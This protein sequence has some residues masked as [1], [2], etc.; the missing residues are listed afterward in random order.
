VDEL[1]TLYEKGY[2]E[3]LAPHGNVVGAVREI[4]RSCPDVE[5]HILSAYL[6][7][8]AYALQEKNGWLDRHLP[9]IGRA[10]RVFVPCG[11]DKKEGIP[12]G[13][14]DSDFLLDDYTSNLNGWQPP[15]RG[16]KLLNAINH[17]RGSWK[18]DRIRYDREP[19][20]L[21]DG[22][23]SVMRGE[24]QIFDQKPGRP[25]RADRRAAQDV[26]DREPAAGEGGMTHGQ[27]KGQARGAGRA[28]G[29][30]SR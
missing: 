4:I 8:S 16:I 9:E 3:K 19:A 26:P 14:R 20:E 21:A 5:V 11:S 23:L 6:A 18:H 7:D 12:G 30:G 28:C 24:R 27:G 22:I 10:H 15:A 1:E 29:R 2:F 13:I 25:G 17:T